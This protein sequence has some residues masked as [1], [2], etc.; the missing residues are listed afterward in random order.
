M[1]ENEIQ[2]QHPTSFD[3]SICYWKFYLRSINNDQNNRG[4]LIKAKIISSEYNGKSLDF[5]YVTSKSGFAIY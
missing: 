3:F 2:I 4:K 5:E 1:R